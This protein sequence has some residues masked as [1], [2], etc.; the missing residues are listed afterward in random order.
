MNEYPPLWIGDGKRV[1]G[2]SKAKT[3]GKAPYEGETFPI[4]R[5]FGKVYARSNRHVK[6]LYRLTPGEPYIIFGKVPANITASV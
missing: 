1:S 5:L 3:Y 2:S 4:M 6:D